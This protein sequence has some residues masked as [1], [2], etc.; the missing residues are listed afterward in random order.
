[1]YQRYQALVKLCILKATKRALCQLCQA[2]AFEKHLEIPWATEQSDLYKYTF[3]FS[4][5]HKQCHR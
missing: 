3:L 5:K 2:L 1:M 4:Y